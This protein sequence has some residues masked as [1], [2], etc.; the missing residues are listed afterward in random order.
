VRHE[1]EWWKFEDTIATKVNLSEVLSHQA[2]LLFYEKV[3]DQATPVAHG[4]MIDRETAQQFNFACTEWI[5][6]AVP[7]K[8]DMSEESLAEVF[9]LCTLFFDDS[10]E[11]D[12]VCHSAPG[13]V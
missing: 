7:M 10:E 9:E 13:S 1:E 4:T 11:S 5:P 3:S 8:G 2:Y 6:E 12:S